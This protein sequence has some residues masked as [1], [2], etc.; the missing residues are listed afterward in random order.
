MDSIGS[1]YC[2]RVHSLGHGYKATDCIFIGLFKC[3][4]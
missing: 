4:S 2:A 3:S 1:E